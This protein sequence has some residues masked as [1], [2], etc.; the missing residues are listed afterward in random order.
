M[1]KGGS[2]IAW[3]LALF[4]V[5]N[6]FYILQSMQTEHPAHH[7][8]NKV[9]HLTLYY[10]EDSD[11]SFKPS[12]NDRFLVYSTH[13]G[14]SNQ[15]LGLSRAAL[16]ANISNR[17]LVVPP[18]LHHGQL[19]FGG[20]AACNTQGEQRIIEAVNNIYKNHKGIGRFQ[21]IFDFDRRWLFKTI[22]LKIIFWDEFIELG[23]RIGGT[24]WD[25]SYSTLG[26]EQQPSYT[27]VKQE[28]RRSKAKVLQIGS[29][30]MTRVYRFID[31]EQNAKRKKSFTQLLDYF[32]AQV[33]WRKEIRDVADLLLKSSFSVPNEITAVHIRSGD[34]N[35]R[36]AAMIRE[37]T[38][39]L[40]QARREHRN[41][42]F[43][44]VFLATDLKDGARNDKLGDFIAQ[45]DKVLDLRN[46]EDLEGNNLVTAASRKLNIDV[47]LLRLVL[48]QHICSIAKSFHATFRGSTFSNIIRKRRGSPRQLTNLSDVV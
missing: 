9:S 44:E 16:L 3:V 21:D 20:K 36:A 42:S 45:Y 28:L 8:D 34:F 12:P 25:F 23:F 30:F 13:S 29:A 2:I 41:S 6:V 5:W 15:V 10:Q 11:T 4:A 26:C 32:E 22:G 33:P 35:Q 17:V 27:K 24:S 48:D 39:Y 43:F 19:S 47:E 40:N 38:A 18:I 7:S 46:L 14:F 31:Q 1:A 37:T